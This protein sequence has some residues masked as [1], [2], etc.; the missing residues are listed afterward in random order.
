MRYRGSNWIRKEKRLAIYM[1]DGMRCVYCGKSY[2]KTL[3]TLDH[4]KPVDSGGSN[5]KYNLITCCV[6]CNSKKQNIQMLDFLERI[7]PDYFDRMAIISKINKLR[8]RSIK[9]LLI[10]AK[11]I[12]YGKEE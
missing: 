6:S 3:L 8:N 9:R 12:L 2:E 5:N 10:D 11:E 7:I 4:I 1:R